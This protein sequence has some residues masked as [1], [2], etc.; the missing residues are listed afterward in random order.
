MN[1]RLA[2]FQATSLLATYNNRDQ[3]LDMRGNASEVDSHRLFVHMHLLLPVSENRLIA[4][5]LLP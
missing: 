1:L 2:F 5:M 3:V 4:P